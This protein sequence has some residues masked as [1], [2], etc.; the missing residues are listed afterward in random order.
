M[1]RLEIDM[2]PKEAAEVLKSSYASEVRE[3]AEFKG[4]QVSVTVAKEKI[5]EMMRFL[6]DAPELQF[7][8]LS[9]ICGADYMGKKEP[10]YEVVY[11]VFSLL[12]KAYL[13][14]KAQVAEDDLAIDSVMDIWVGA[15]WRER[16]C[17]DM[18]GITFKDH[19]DHRRLLMPDDWDGFPLRKDYPLEADLGD[20]E[21]KGYLDV[22][23]TYER[24]KKYEVHSR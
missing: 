3:V 9:D 17:F 4:G 21:W 13:T 8:F 5:R 19:T 18:Y 23:E 10:R 7:H 24:N 22:I 11:V 6:H 2:G 16:E 20:R 14:V 1:G 12:N 15:D